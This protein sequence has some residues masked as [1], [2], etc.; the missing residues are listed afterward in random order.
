MKKRT[1]ILSFFIGLVQ[2]LLICTIVFA[3]MVWK[4]SQPRYYE[5]AGWTVTKDVFISK[6]EPFFYNYFQKK[7]NNLENDIL[8]DEYLET[9]TYSLIYKNE[10]LDILIVFYTP[11]SESY[12]KFTS[13]INLYKDKN[14]TIGYNLFQNVDEI[15]SEFGEEFFFDFPIEE[16]VFKDIYV[17]ELLE[18]D[19]HVYFTSII[20]E[21]N[22]SYSISLSEEN[23]S[24]K[25]CVSS[26]IKG[27]DL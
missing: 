4:F 26:L 27:F 22:S 3:C 23:L 8:L 12:C 25:L 17:E 10:Q 2:L 14:S 1:I 21:I 6:Y 15:I 18:N 24:I 5:K 19:H 7:F 20:G 16:G 11:E 13:E 9:D